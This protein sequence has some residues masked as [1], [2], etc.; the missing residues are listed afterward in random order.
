MNERFEKLLD[1]EEIRG[2]RIKYGHFLDSK[3]IDALGLLF[4]PDA[5]CQLEGDPLEGRAAICLGLEKA[6]DLYDIEKHGS[7]P[8]LHAVTNH[9]IE[10]LDKDKAQG[11]CYLLDLQTISKPQRDPW[12][13]LGMY[14]DEYRRIEGKW[15]ISRSRLDMAWPE[16]NVG[17]GHPGKDLVLPA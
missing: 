1:L 7:Y 8:F 15:Y 13:L 9:W 2:L 12:I 17:G 16:R 3:S 5:I 11:R 4:S 14:A 10:F 6:F